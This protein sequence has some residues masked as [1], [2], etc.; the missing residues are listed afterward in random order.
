MPRSAIARDILSRYETRTVA[1][2][3]CSGFI[4]RAL[5]AALSGTGAR[6]LLVSR[7]APAPFRGADVLTADLREP[8]GWH[9]IARRA[10][11]VFHLAGNTSV[12][13]AAADPAESFRATLLPVAHLI[14]AAQDAGRT[15]RVVY[16]STETVY[17]LPSRLPVGEDVQPAPVTV[18]DRHKWWAEQL[19]E[20]ASTQGELCGV[21]LRLP[22]VYGPSAGMSTA[23]D[24]GVLNKVAR[25][26][27]LGA[28][29]PLYGEGSYLRDFVYID[30][31][32]AAFLMAGTQP[33][34]TGLALNV[35]SGQG[36]T[37]R[38][39]FR[40]VAD[41]ARQLAGSTSR[42]QSVPW[43]DDADAIEFRNYVA[44]VRRIASA[45]GWTPRVSLAE[46]VDRLL[47]FLMAGG[48][49]RASENLE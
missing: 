26:A 17:G 49:A 11:I 27:L 20:Q 29:L 25:L 42:V 3:G 48:V 14:A 15:P 10:D 43:P 36:V 45:C 2:T 32:V 40:M 28:D 44:D 37:V 22:T 41:R 31:V 24:R 1:V 30:D 34:I 33:D 7:R 18:Y 47:R 6:L 9:E 23:D 35:G 13:A 21:S 19:L 38:D 8:G 5:T 4:G 46:G 16:A 39:A 12:Y